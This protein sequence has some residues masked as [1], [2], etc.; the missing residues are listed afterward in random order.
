[1]KP[2]QKADLRRIKKELMGK[3]SPGATTGIGD[4]LK[5][6]YDTDNNGVVDDAE[7][8]DGQPSSAFAAA[9]HNHD[10][11]YVKLTDYE[12]ADVLTKIKNVDGSGS[13]LDADQLDGNEAT[14]FAQATHSHAG[15]DITSQVD[16]SDKVDGQHATAFAQATHIHPV[17]TT[18]ANGFMAQLP[19][20]QEKFYN[21]KG[22]WV[23]L[24]AAAGQIILWSAISDNVRHNNATEHLVNATEP[25]LYKEI[26]FN[27]PAKNIRIKWQLEA[28]IDRTIYAAI[29][30]NGVRKSDWIT[31]PYYEHPPLASYDFIDKINS[32]DKIQIYCYQDQAALA[33]LIANMQLCY[34]RAICGFGNYTLVTPL[35][36]NEFVDYNTTDNDPV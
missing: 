9:A 5:A 2:A 7:K 21:G 24:V 13:G 18:L 15:S 29:Y 8:L 32:G 27:E 19:D 11:A 20:D 6:V 35:A 17:V 14:A 22:S 33:G 10:L 12:D 3:T 1:M 16:D 23:E 36:V 34:D 26:I 31:R 30:V 25:T 28:G 4:M